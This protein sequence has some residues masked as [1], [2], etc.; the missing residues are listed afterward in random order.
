M[1]VATIQGWPRLLQR[2]ND[3]RSYYSKPGSFMVQ[4]ILFTTLLLV[5]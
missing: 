3:R 2:N 1:T 4:I 5:P